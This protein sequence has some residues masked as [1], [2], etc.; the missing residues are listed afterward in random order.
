MKKL[1]FLTIAVLMFQTKTFAAITMEKTESSGEIVASIG[2]DPKINGF[3]FRNFGENPDYEDDLTLDDLIG[4]M[5]VKDDADGNFED[6]DCTPVENEK[7]E[8]KPEN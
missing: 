4:K 2:F 5:C 3:G 7:P 6:E 8:K 1:L